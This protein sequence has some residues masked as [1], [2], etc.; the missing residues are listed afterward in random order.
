LWEEESV[1]LTLREFLEAFVKGW[2]KQAVESRLAI[3]RGHSEHYAEVVSNL[4]ADLQIERVV[5]QAMV[6]EIQGA[7]LRPGSIEAAIRTTFQPRIL[8]GASG[9]LPP[10]RLLGRVTPLSV[11]ANRG[12]AARVFPSARYA[13]SMI[14][15]YRFSPLRAIQRDW[16]S[17]RLLGK[18][19][20]W[21]FFRDEEGRL[22]FD[23]LKLTR[24]H[25]CAQTGLPLATVK[26]EIVYYNYLVPEDVEPKIPRVVEAYASLPWNC[27]FRSPGQDDIKRGHGRTRVWDLLRTRNMRGFPEVV[28]APVPGAYLASQPIVI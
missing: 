18:H 17:R 13:R 16:G 20:M 6:D 25:L 28:H 21:G 3:L 9:S 14:R 11:L 19:A 4:Y 15:K 8:K 24:E 22:P 5:W 23:A 2:V 12:V 26:R 27:F 10:S 7:S 1:P